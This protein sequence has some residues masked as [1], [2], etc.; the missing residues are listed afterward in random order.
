MAISTNRF[1]GHS[2]WNS[3]RVDALFYRVFS[4]SLDP[5]QPFLWGN[6]TSYR[7]Q[8]KALR[9]LEW[10]FSW[11]AHWL[12]GIISNCNACSATADWR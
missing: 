4:H 2:R 11:L 10:C 6:M 7:E 9:R 3:D 8:W 1:M 12:A 5:K